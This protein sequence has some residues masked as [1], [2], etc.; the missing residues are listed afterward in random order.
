MRDA[1]GALVTAVDYGE[2]F[3]WPSAS[4]G[5]GPSMELLHPSL[6]P[7]LGGSWRRAPTVPT[8]GAVNAAKLATYSAAPPAIR[9]V[10]H[11]PQQPTSNTAVP[12]TATVTDPDGVTSVILRYQIVVPGSYIRKADA[13]FTAASAESISASVCTVR[14]ATV[15]PYFR[16]SLAVRTSRKAAITGGGGG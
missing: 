1:G 14:S 5:S 11:T 8:P 6:D 9:Q 13:A 3:P 16:A 15:G 4:R 10:N 2:G 7:G 12:I